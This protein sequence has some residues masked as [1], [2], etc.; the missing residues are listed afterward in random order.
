MDPR[1]E[2][3]HLRYFLAVADAESFT[4]AAERLGV[5][6]S[7]V[8]QQVMDLEGMLGTPLFRRLGRRLQLTEAGLTLRA[9]AGSAVRRVEEACTLATHATDAQAGHLEVGVVPGAIVAWVPAAL[10][11]MSVRHPAVTVAVHERA[12]SAIDTEVE[13]GRFDLGCGV[14]TRASPNLRYES[15]VQ[16]PVVLIVPSG[17]AL[18]K[19]SSINVKELEHV[20][21]VLL[22][23]SFDMRRIVDDL[24]RR[25]HVKPRVAYE[26]SSIPS[27]LATV[28]RTG[29]ATILTSLVLTGSEASKLRGIPLREP[30]MRIDFGIVSARAGE[31]SPTAKAFA[32]VLREHCRGA[33]HATRDRAPESSSS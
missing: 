6:Q 14:L 7:S 24:F 4:R 27:T 17:H 9:S 1:I 28:L 19:R 18:A 33:A 31:P 10:E 26:I 20:P 8:S 23:H 11:Q 25:A 2:L 15:L 5:S 29:A 12:A 13:A 22:P 30:A 21:L 16:E 3:R 32:A